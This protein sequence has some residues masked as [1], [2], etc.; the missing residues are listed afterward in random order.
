MTLVLITALVI[1]VGIALIMAAKKRTSPLPP[2][3]KGLPLIGSINAFPPQGVAPW[4]YW[5]KHKDLYGPIS[6]VTAWGTTLIIL[7]S[8]ELA[9]ELFEKRS[10]IYST[11]PRGVFGGEMVG[12]GK[13]LALL[14]YDK[15]YRAHRK[16]IHMMV[17]T[18]MAALRY[19]PFQVT[20]VHQFLFSVLQEPDKLLEHVRSDSAAVFLKMIYGYTVDSSKPD[21]LVA[22]VTESTALFSDAL[23]PGGWLVDMIP[24][25]RYIP[26]WVPGTGFKKIAKAWRACVTETVEKPFRF[27]R[28]RI[29]KGEDENSYVAD[30]GSVLSPEDEDIVKWTAVTLY[31]AGADTIAST[32]TTFFAAMVRYPELQRKAQ[33]EID[34]VIG[35]GRLP[36]LGDRDQLPYINAIVTETW[37]WQPMLR[38]GIPHATSADDVVN[39][40][41]IPKGSVVTTNIWW[42]TH[43]PDVYPNPSVFDPSRFLGANPCPDPRDHVFGYGRRICPGRYFAD[44][45]IWLIIAQSLAV[46]DISKP[47]GEIEEPQTEEPA[48]YI[49]GGINAH[50]A[51]FKATVKP[52]SSQHEALIREVEALH[53]REKSSA[54]EL[55]SIVI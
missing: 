16:R 10:K 35:S 27:A 21:P 38:L 32:A 55:E 54:D 40:Y 17:G 34:R 12:W 2:G 47:F 48:V 39:G 37:R 23:V 41:Y 24:A 51:P 49:T 45:F 42:Y 26:E 5:L 6:S 29:I 14:P 7:N 50:L 9:S 36:E 46:F 44:A 8:H 11:R 28:R 25:L 1:G 15:V 52:R 33:E 20:G 19:L 53:P 31:A 4:E 18:E 3:P 22:L 30:F 43:D 13:N